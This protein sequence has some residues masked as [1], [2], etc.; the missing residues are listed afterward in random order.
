LAGIAQE[1]DL[2]DIGDSSA[3]A[4]TPAEERKLGEQLIRQLRRNLAFIDD[5]EVSEY[6]NNLGYRLVSQ[7]D[8]PN[9][10]FSFLLINDP[11]INA[12]ALPGGYI[13][14]HSGLIRKTVVE[15]ELAAVV[16]HEI[17]HVSQRHIARAI[18]RGNLSGLSTMAGVL[19]AMVLASQ[20]PELGQATLTAAIAS[21]VQSQ[22]NFTRT[23]EKEA[24]RVGID[25]MARAGF[26]P[27]S[28]P[29]FFERLHKATRLYGE[30]PPEFLSTHPVTTSR[31]SDSYNRAEQIKLDKP[32]TEYTSYL[33][34]RAKLRVL[35]DEPSDSINY[36]RARLKEHLPAKNRAASRYGL[37]MSY[38]KNNQPQNAKPIISKLIKSDPNRLPYHSALAKI[39]MA[40]N[41]P[42]KALTVY[43]KALNMNPENH[44]ITTY[45]TEALLNMGK[46][47]LATPILR[48]HIRRYRNANPYLYE[49]LARAEGKAGDLSAAHRAQ[50]EFYYLSGQTFAAIEQLKIAKKIESLSEFQKLRIEARLK[51]L[52]LIAMEEER[53]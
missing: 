23:N 42:N 6:L 17:A 21:S 14:V 51:Q 53:S 37:A 16:G 45:Y 11:S 52:E 7:F 41:H 49:L 40:S 20:N 27:K 31:M 22:I 29:K 34:I 30:Q 32:P 13:V 33:I 38:L 2:P 46:A 10:K 1:L 43:Q 39:E 19:A 36:F 25:L 5:P 4:I 12:F 24:D 35:T 3:V 47:D 9:Q 50:A 15:S 8:S 48:N 18:E 44:A 26:D 28:M